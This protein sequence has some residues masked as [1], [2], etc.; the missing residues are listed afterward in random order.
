MKD[1]ARKTGIPRIPF[2]ST[3]SKVDPIPSPDAKNC[4]LPLLPTPAQC[5]GHWIWLGFSAPLFQVVV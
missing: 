2:T 5:L 1:S 3:T 4:L